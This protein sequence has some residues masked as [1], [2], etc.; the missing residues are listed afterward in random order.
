MYS[1]HFGLREAPFGGNPDSRFFYANATYDEA[2][3]TL[4]Y[5]IRARKGFALLIGDVGT[6]KTTLLHRLMEDLGESTRF[7]FLFNPSLSFDEILAAICADLGLDVP[8]G[9]RLQQIYALNAFLLDQQRGGGTTALLIDEGQALSDDSLER[10]R[11]LSNFET[12]TEKLF[13]IVIAGQPELEARLLG[14]YELRQLRQRITLRC[15][16]E[17]LCAFEVGDFIR[18]RLC[19]AGAARD[20]IF[21]RDA[22][23][24][25]ARI[26]WGV[27]RLIN[28]IC[29]NALLIAYGTSKSKVTS[30]IVAEVARDL[31]LEGRPAAASKPAPSARSRRFDWRTLWQ[32]REL[33]PSPVATFALAAML[34]IVLAIVSGPSLAEWLERA[35]VGRPAERR[36]SAAG[37]I[38]SGL[39]MVGGSAM[40]AAPSAAAPIGSEESCKVLPAVTLETLL[41]RKLDGSLRLIVASVPSRAAAVALA[42]E[43]E[44]RTGLRAAA[45]SRRDERRK[46][47]HEVEIL[48]LEDATDANRAWRS[49]ASGDLLG[50]YAPRPTAT[51]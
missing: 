39:G 24:E 30:E 12:T 16:L 23:R 14:Q 18:S 38:S 26:S 35:D 29:D 19:A 7:V 3:A 1:S 50:G 33:A 8:S 5:A 41:R 28:V 44:R 9:E 47:V 4:R 25:I 45:S 40:P 22:I 43:V 11:L 27:P 51:K 15:R 48:G 46:T 37:H 6:G 17:P 21:T 49:V 32:H 13:Q 2:Y 20:N 10:L 36:V 31:R 42:G 34:V